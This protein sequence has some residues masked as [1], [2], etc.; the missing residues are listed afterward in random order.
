[1]SYLPGVQCYTP[2][3]ANCANTAS[4]TTVLSFVIPANQMADQDVIQVIM[5]GLFKNNKGTSGA[6]VGKVNVGAGAQVTLHNGTWANSA[7]EYPGAAIWYLIRVGADV[8]VVWHLLADINTT[9][10]GMSGS[11]AGISTPAN[12]TSDQTV[13]FK[14]TLAAA[15]ATYYWKITSAK[16][17]HFKG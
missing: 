5:T 4:E 1:M 8:K 17:V 14:V 6:T 15:D 11:I 16:V 9:P 2:T 10:A 13:S 7:S 3:L 12:F